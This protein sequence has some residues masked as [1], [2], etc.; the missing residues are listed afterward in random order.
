[1]R[2]MRL[3]RKL[4]V[5]KCTWLCLLR[6]VFGCEARAFVWRAREVGLVECASAGDAR[7]LDVT[8]IFGPS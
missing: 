1:M 4:D 5:A 7:V 2:D 6:S 8:V 3:V